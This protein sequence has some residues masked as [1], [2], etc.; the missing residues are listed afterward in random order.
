ML[1]ICFYSTSLS[2]LVTNFYTVSIQIHNKFL[3]FIKAKAV[4][5]VNQ[6]Q[7]LLSVQSLGHVQIFATPLTAAHQ[8]SLS[9]TISRSLLKF[10]SIESVMPS[11]HLILFKNNSCNASQ[12]ALAVK[13]PPANAGDI[14][15]P[16]LIPGNVPWRRK[17]QSPPVFL[18]RESHGQRS[19]VGCSLQG[20]RGSDTTEATQHTCTRNET[21]LL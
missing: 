10:I 3:F 6:D 2:A 8:T 5:E 11:N 13:N 9:F 4:V 17:W 14:R 1:G 19:L 16:G 20:C 7:F 15:D 21:C 18:P 12:V